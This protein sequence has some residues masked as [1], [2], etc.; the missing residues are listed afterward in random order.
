MSAGQEALHIDADVIW[1]ESRMKKEGNRI[2]APNIFTQQIDP[3]TL[4]SVIS[5]HV[6]EIQYHIVH[7]WGWVL[8]THKSPS[9]YRIVAPRRRNAVFKKTFWWKVLYPR[10]SYK[11]SSCFWLWR[12]IH[13]VFTDTTSI[14][15]RGTTRF[16][17]A[18]YLLCI[19]ANLKK[20]VEPVRRSASP[21]SSSLNHVANW[22]PAGENYCF[23]S[24]PSSHQ[25]R[26]GR[27]CLH[28]P[29]TSHGLKPVVRWVWLG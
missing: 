25:G 18:S 1:E 12:L 3:L 26:V 15:G 9:P 27:F 19:P 14:F 5:I 4:S 28:R 10:V 13:S 6:I 17:G 7:L 24:V 29:C 11:Q 23:T 21:R 16:P 20:N 2:L 8:F 22:S